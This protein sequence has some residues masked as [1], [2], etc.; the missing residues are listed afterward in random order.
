M[1]DIQA[2]EF[3]IF[4]SKLSIIMVLHASKIM[5]DIDSIIMHRTHAKCEILIKIKYS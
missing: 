5:F 1:F 4:E 2:K 3:D